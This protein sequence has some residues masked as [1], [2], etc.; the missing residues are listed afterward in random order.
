MARIETTPAAQPGRTP[1]APSEGALPTA[2]AGA[3]GVLGGLLRSHGEAQRAT[4]VELFF[5]LVYVFAITQLSHFLLAHTAVRGALDTLLLFAMVWLVWAYTTWVTNW[6]DPQ[7][8]PIRSLLLVLMTPAS[9]NSMSPLF[10]TEM[11]P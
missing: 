8:L 10:E 6:L 11:T 4:N 5:D 1:G 2:H 3:R 9:T 7:R